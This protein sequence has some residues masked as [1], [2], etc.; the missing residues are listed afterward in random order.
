VSGLEPETLGQC[1]SNTSGQLFPKFQILNVMY[2]PPGTSGVV[3]YSNGS[4][5][6]TTNVSTGTWNNGVTLSV[7]NKDSAFGFAAGDLSLSAT[8]TSGGGNSDSTDIKEVTTTDLNI[9]G[10]GDEVNHDLDRIYLLLN[11][12]VDVTFDALDNSQISEGLGIRDTGQGAIIRYVLAGWV[13]NPTT[14][15]TNVE[16]ALQGFNITPADYPT[17]LEADPFFSTSQAFDRFVLQAQYPYEPAAPGQNP[18]PTGYTLSNTT[19]T[20]A[21]TSQTQSFSISAS[22]SGSSSFLSL[23]SL[24]IKVQDTYTT[25]QT[26]S[27]SKNSA[28]TVSAHASIPQPGSTYTGPI[29][30]YIYLDTIY[31]TFMFDI[32]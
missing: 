7:T 2:A 17:M 16:S 8:S 5:L 30:L 15:P 28:T 19:T 32:H 24:S 14:M 3:D 31:N 11:P 29:G 23:I 26:N 22:A 20:V 10:N 6:G 9:D 13:R 21:T 18:A 27:F 4:T 25:T 1:L 12:Q